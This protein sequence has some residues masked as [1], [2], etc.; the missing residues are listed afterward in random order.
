MERSERTANVGKR[1]N[2]GTAAIES[3]SQRTESRCVRRGRASG[4]AIERDVG[5]E[6]V[7]R[8]ARSE[9]S[10]AVGPV[11]LESGPNCEVELTTSGSVGT[12]HE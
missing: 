11:S 1:R 2:L 4:R 5:T 3:A 9:H 6:F 12:R 8:E 7:R 10:E